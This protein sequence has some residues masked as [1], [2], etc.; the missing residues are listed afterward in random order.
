MNTRL[1]IFLSLIA[2]LSWLVISRYMAHAPWHEGHGWVAL[3]SFA[4]FL[5]LAVPL[6]T[7][8]FS[9]ATYNEAHPALAKIMFAL[10]YLLYA[11]QGV[12]FCL[13]F[14]VFMGDIVW[15]LWGALEPELPTAALNR[16]VFL[17]VTACTA[18]TAASG[19]FQAFSGPKIVRVDIPIKNLPPAFDGYKIVQVS[20]LHVGPLITAPYVRKVAQRALALNADMAAFTG[21]MVDGS[22][23]HLKDDLAPLLALRPKDGVFFIPGNHEYYWNAGDWVNYWRGAGAEVLLDENRLIRRGEAV[24]AVAGV[25]D[26]MTR[27]SGGCDVARAAEGIPPGTVKILLAHQPASYA[28]AEKAG[29]DLQLSGHTHGGQF[30]PWSLMIGLFHRYA[31]GLHRHGK[32]WIYVSCGTG[33][34]GPPLRAGAPS[35]I[36]LLTLK[37]QA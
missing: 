37:T 29:F 31:R 20:D 7:E 15:L 24:L 28:D 30:I 5:M 16:W 22:V 36:T 6:T 21:D 9:P 10:A 13:L 2:T 27:R 17:G 18:L 19:L 25:T 4:V 14:Y 32:T 11:L 23:A 35:E 34:W 8:I 12:F 3:A 33:F 1:V 26:Y